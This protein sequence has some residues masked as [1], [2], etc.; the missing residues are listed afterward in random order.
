M[1]AKTAL[2]QIEDTDDTG[3]A[4][5]VGATTCRSE[6]TAPAADAEQHTPGAPDVDSVETTALTESAAT[7]GASLMAAEER[8]THTKSVTA[9]HH[10]QKSNPARDHRPRTPAMVQPQP[11][12]THYQHQRIL[13][14]TT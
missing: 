13:S 2:H 9:E 1:E 14:G 10:T 11:T 5:A 8:T 3:G 6:D 7:A 12:H 4:T